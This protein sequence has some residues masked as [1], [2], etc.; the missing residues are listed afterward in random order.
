M[1]LNPHPLESL[2]GPLRFA[3]AR[4]FASLGS[5]K[6]LRTP[7]AAALNRSRKTLPPARVAALEAELSFIDSPVPEARKASIRR[8]V[9]VLRDEGLALEG[10]PAVLSERSRGASVVLGIPTTEKRPSTPLGQNG[11]PFSARSFAQNFTAE[12]SAFAFALSTITRS[13]ASLPL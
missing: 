6:D 8:V 2:V 3:C 1:S 5:L 12:R 10:I 11:G 13:W 4:D 7:L 9:Q